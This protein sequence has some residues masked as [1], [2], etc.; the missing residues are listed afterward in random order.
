MVETLKNV[1][2]NTKSLEALSF[3]VSVSCFFFMISPTTLF[4]E[5]CDTNIIITHNHT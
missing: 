3:E 5:H 1:T 2:E 4:K